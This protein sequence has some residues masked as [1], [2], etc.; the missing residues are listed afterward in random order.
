M[1]PENRK[2][3][4]TLRSPHCLAQNGLLVRGDLRYDLPREGRR[5]WFPDL[6]HREAFLSASTQTTTRR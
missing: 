5:Y 1:D 6:S 3:P 2:P 4:L